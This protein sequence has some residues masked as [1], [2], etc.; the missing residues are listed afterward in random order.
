MI[1]SCMENNEN[2]TVPHCK[3]EQSLH[4]RGGA[5]MVN[6]VQYARAASPVVHFACAMKQAKGVAVAL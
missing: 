4:L 2:G 1:S 3:L 5:D 6:S